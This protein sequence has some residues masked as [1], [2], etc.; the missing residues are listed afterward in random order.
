MP[1]AIVVGL[2]QLASLMVSFTFIPA[3]SARLLGR[4]RI[5]R[6]GAEWGG[7]VG[8]EQTVPLY[9]RFYAALV[10]WALRNPW[11]TVTIA[12]G[13]FGG[14]AWLFD[15]YVTRGVVWGGGGS[16]RTFID[17][18]VRLPR[19]SDLERTDELVGFFEDK[20]AR[21][22]EV[23]RYASLVRGTFGVVH[24]TFPDSLET[25]YVPV[26]IKEQMEDYSHSF[27]GADV[28]V[29]GYGPS[30]YGGDASAPNY[31][32]TVLGYNYERVRDIAEDLGARLAR[33]ARIV[34]VD[35][36]ASDRFT[37][38]RAVEYVLRIDRDALALYDMS[39]QDLVVRLQAAIGGSSGVS[40][41]RLGGEEVQFQVKFEGS[42]QADVPAL[43][44]TLIRLPDGR[45]VRLGDVVTVAP[46]EVLANILRENQQY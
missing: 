14:S 16:Q 25:T 36:N 35:T 18:Q 15:R 11:V 10:G 33:M 1:L 7:R 40:T 20:I 26:A 21:L 44:Q 42:E 27:T 24:V 28:R 38:D 4:A 32:L 2:S 29:Y 43:L 23:D 46:R 6:P 34:E 12:A 41:L 39:V 19:G 31:R 22:A 13:M 9:A 8:S 5:R 30:F 37:R 17:I 45:Q 3:L